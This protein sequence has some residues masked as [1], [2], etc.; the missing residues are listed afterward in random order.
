MTREESWED[1]LKAQGVR[2]CRWLRSWIEWDEE[3]V[4]MEI[5]EKYGVEVK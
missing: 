5:A 1:Y 4:V 2:L 3:G